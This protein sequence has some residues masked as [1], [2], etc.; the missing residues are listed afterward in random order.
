MRTGIL[1]RGA[2]NTAQSCMKRSKNLSLDIRMED[3]ALE[4]RDIAELLGVE[5]FLGLV[6]LCGGQNIY[7]PK[8]ESVIRASRDR[9]MMACFSGDNY[10]ELARKYG[11]TE[12]RIR[13]IIDGSRYRQ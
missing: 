6:R 12:R 8:M 9:T 1:I 7:I 10:K 11:L 13:K 3:I 4:Y 5:S 2:A